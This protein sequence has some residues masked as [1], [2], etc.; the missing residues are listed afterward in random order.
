MPYDIYIIVNIVDISWALWYIVVNI[1]TEIDLGI[2][3]MNINL[4]R[5]AM[6]LMIMNI[7]PYCGALW[8]VKVIFN[9]LVE[10]Y[11]CW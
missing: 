6:W 9:Q 10:P 5:G 4:F 11:D 3:I 2:L 7:D 1:D 8:L